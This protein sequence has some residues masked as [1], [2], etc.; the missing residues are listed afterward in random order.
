M[1]SLADPA[2]EDIAPEPV[3]AG[4]AMLV[5]G[6]HGRPHVNR[7]LFMNADGYRR[8]WVGYD[9]AGLAPGQTAPAALQGAVA[10]CARVLASTLPR[11]FETAQRAAPG[12]MI[13]SC[14]VF[15]EAPLPPPALPAWFMA[16]P[17]FWG[18]VA[19]V[20]WWF[21][22]SGGEESREQAEAR[23]LVAVER[24][25]EE[26][27]RH[28]SV[29]LLAHGWFNRMMRPVL[30]ARGWR[31]VEDGGDTYWSFRVYRKAV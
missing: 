6:R 1:P 7:M 31:C 23:A 14:E 20:C 19:R 9:A 24:L 10:R 16:Q 28:G 11:A 4:E 15:V 5:I 17:G 18:V 27:A 8:W 12:R 30:L 3:G 29:A 22:R 2:T 21:G 26:A 25:E 13:E